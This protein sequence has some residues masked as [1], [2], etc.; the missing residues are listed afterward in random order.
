MSQSDHRLCAVETWVEKHRQ[1]LE[2]ATEW[3]IGV[4]DATDDTLADLL[5]KIGSS[6]P[7]ER[8]NIALQLG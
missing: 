4:K 3:K 1:T 7:Q 2:M 8:E 6:Q 5:T